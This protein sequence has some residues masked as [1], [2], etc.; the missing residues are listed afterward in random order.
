MVLINP[1]GCIVMVNRQTERVFGYEQGEM[2]GQPIEML[3]PVR[4]REQHPATV[5]LF[6]RI[7]CS[8]H[9]AGLHFVGSAKTAVSSQRT[10]H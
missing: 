5:A 4:Y 9:G 10:S 3:V 8:A 6:R 7:K 2:L 1:E